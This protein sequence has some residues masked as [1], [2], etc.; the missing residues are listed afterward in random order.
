MMLRKDF[1]YCLC[2]E[3]KGKTEVCPEFLSLLDQ[4]WEEYGFRQKGA[5]SLPCR[6]HELQEILEHSKENNAGIESWTT[7]NAT[8]QESY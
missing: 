1:F 5:L 4:T 3:G 2:S 7:C 8:I 6:P